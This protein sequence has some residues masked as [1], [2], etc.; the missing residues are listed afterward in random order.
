MIR[1]TV[2]TTQVPSRFQRRSFMRSETRPQTTSPIPPQIYGTIVN[3]PTVMLSF[4]PM[5]LMICGMKNST[6]RL[7]VTMPK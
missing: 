2:D 7:A 1:P 4:T 3:Q 5:D 6:P